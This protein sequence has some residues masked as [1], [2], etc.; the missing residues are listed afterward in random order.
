MARKLLMNLLLLLSILGGASSAFGTD[1]PY[2][3]L[4]LRLQNKEQK[5][6]QI[7]FNSTIPEEEPRS[8]QELTEE[9][10]SYCRKFPRVAEC[11]DLVAIM[12]PGDIEEI[13]ARK[14]LGK[15]CQR[16]RAMEQRT[17]FKRQAACRSGLGNRKC[18]LARNNA[19]RQGY[20]DRR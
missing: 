1:D 6:S 10:K 4:R 20:L 15:K 3:E 5:R 12:K 17:M 9:K 16:M 2:E 14:P 11:A 13:C 8:L 18:M 7:G 19:R